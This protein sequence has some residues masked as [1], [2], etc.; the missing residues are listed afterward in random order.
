MTEE[1][2][3]AAERR[4]QAAQLASDVAALDELIDDAMRFTGPDGSLS[5][6]QDD[7][8]AHES[9]R[10]VV[11]HLQEEDLR[12]FAAEHVG[13]TWFLGTLEATVDGQPLAARMRYTRTWIPDGR[14]GWKVIAAHATIVGSPVTK[15]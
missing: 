14:E 8:R 3:R 5:S 10:Q 1:T 2:L 4:L 13:V 12:V 6:K 11:S 15:P 9:G 7:L